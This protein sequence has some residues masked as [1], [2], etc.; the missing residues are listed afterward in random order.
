MHA[1]PFFDSAWRAFLD[2]LHRQIGIVDFADILF[3]RSHFYVQEQRRQDPSYGPPLEPLF[4]EKEG[5]IA[6]ANRGRDPLY[7][8][9]ALQRQLGYPE[10]PRPKPR[11]DLEAR[12]EALKAKVRE[13][14]QRLKL[15]EGETRGQVDL[16]EFLVKPDKPPKDAEQD[17]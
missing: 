4:G 10:V 13:L 5:K 12:L 15:V 3:L 14:E 2:M 16:S 6:K 1:D 7:L 8:F 9:A 11:D 17:A